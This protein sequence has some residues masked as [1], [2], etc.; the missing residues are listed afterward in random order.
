MTWRGASFLRKHLQTSTITTTPSSHDSMT[1]GRHWASDSPGPDLQAA[2]LRRHATPAV[3][4][5]GLLLDCLCGCG[6]S[7]RQRWAVL[8]LLLLL[9]MLLCPP[10]LLLLS[11]LFPATPPLLFPTTTAAAAVWTDAHPPLEGSNLCHLTPGGICG[12]SQNCFFFS[13]A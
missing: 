2:E 8:L 9:L 3:P 11:L 10:K 4:F 5:W 1:D 12:F 7:R 13:S 6:C